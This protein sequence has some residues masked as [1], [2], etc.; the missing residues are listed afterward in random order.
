[1]VVVTLSVNNAQVTIADEDILRFTGSVTLNGSIDTARVPWAFVR[2]NLLVVTMSEPNA[3]FLGYSN[4]SYILSTSSTVSYTSPTRAEVYAPVKG[5]YEFFTLFRNPAGA[6]KIVINEG[7]SVNND[8]FNLFL[9][10]AQAVNPLI[11]HG[12]DQLGNPLASYRA[13]RRALI[14]TLPNLGDFTT[15]FSEGSDTLLIS[16]ASNSHSFKPVEFQV[17][18]MN[19]MTMHTIQFDKFTGMNGPRTAVNSPANFIQQ[20][21]KVKVPPGTP[22]A[23]TATQIWSYTDINGTGGF[24]DRL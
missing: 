6:S 24:G 12:V 21:F 20:H 13:P 7:I 5:T 11:Y 18:L 16:A 1:M 14:T 3:S 17:D 10:A 4:A 15:T 23:L 2:T 8:A 19:T 9:D 22:S